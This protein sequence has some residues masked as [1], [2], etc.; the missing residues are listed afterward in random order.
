M[1]SGGELYF[2][3]STSLG[4]PQCEYQRE[5]LASPLVILQSSLTALLGNINRTRSSTL[6]LSN[7]VDAGSRGHSVHLTGA[8]QSYR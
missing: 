4:V 6:T 8:S 2:Q 1:Y 3:N 5:K 7:H